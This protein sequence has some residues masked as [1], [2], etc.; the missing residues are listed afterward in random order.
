MACHEFVVSFAGAAEI[1]LWGAEARSAVFGPRTP[2]ILVKVSELKTYTQHYSLY[3]L[4]CNISGTT[5]CSL[6]WALS[7]MSLLFATVRQK[8]LHKMNHCVPRRARLGL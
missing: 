4:E 7:L 6:C 1:Q 8:S 2:A 5:H 3:C